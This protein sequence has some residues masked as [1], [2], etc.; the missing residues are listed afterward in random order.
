M[1]TKFGFVASVSM[2][3]GLSFTA[4]VRASEVVYVS[5]TAASPLYTQLTIGTANT[6][7]QNGTMGNPFGSVQAAYAYLYNTPGNHTIRLIHNGSDGTYGGVSIGQNENANGDGVIRMVSANVFPSTDP[8]W[9]TVKLVSDDPQNRVTMRM[10]YPTGQSATDG[11]T[12]PAEGAGSYPAAYEK[13]VPN[14][15]GNSTANRGSV[16]RGLWNA[17]TQMALPGMIV[18]DV[19]IVLGGGHVLVGTTAGDTAGTIKQQFTF[20]NVNVTMEQEMFQ[21][22]SNGP[23]WG[24]SALFVSHANESSLNDSYLSFNDSNI[25]LVN[26]DNSAW[27]GDFYVGHTWGPGGSGAWYKLP[28]DFVT[29]NNTS[30]FNYWNGTAYVEWADAPPGSIWQSGRNSGN[31][32]TAYQNDVGTNN[33]F[34]DL[35]SFTVAVPEPSSLALAGLAGAGLLMSRLLSRRGRSP[36]E[37]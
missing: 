1:N 28:N 33:N 36:E 12:S 34:F 17:G 22:P 7:G 10:S 32:L 25:Y 31:T 30:T 11:I 15:G 18:E 29:G 14:P 26:N 5:R 16:I 8:L 21:A 24:K 20:N 23:I 13:E 35:Q 37:S 27:T 4:D 9:T 3:V 6:L 19:D 2:I